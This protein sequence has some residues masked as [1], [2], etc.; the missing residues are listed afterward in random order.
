MGW[1]WEPHEG[2]AVRQLADGTVTAAWTAANTGF[3]AYVAACSCGWRGTCSHEPTEDGY[4]AAGEEWDAEHWQ[5]L[6]TPELDQVL[7][8]DRDGGGFRHYLAG[9][10]VHCGS[11]LELLVQGGRW[12]GVRY[13]LRAGEP[14]AYL[15]LGGPGEPFG[16]NDCVHFA[17]PVNAVLRWPR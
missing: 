12:V 6:T 10:P 15:G 2:Y 1:G 5:P 9:E 4:E 14:I 7:V 17:V 3:V 8:V 13:E 11:A 16:A